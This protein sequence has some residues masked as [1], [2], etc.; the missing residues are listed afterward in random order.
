MFNG[1]T[2]RFYG[3]FLVP[4]VTS[5]LTTPGEGPQYYP[6]SPRQRRAHPGLPG[7]P[8]GGVGPHDF[9]N[10]H[11]SICISWYMEWN[12]CISCFFFFWSLSKKWCHQNQEF[13]SDEEHLILTIRLF[14][15][16]GAPLNYITKKNHRELGLVC[17]NLLWL[18]GDIS[19]YI[20]N[21]ASI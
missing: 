7:T 19:W 3:H 13:C 12:L 9:G 20:M 11:L 5:H 16:G 17:T 1:K 8:D 4:M 6:L 18:I 2:H 15:Q 14:Q 21:I 10:L